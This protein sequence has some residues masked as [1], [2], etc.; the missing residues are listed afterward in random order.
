MVHGTMAKC[1]LTPDEAMAGQW[2]ESWY[3]SDFDSEQHHHDRWCGIRLNVIAK[4]VFDPGD[5][6]VVIPLH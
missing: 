5:K 6:Q 2:N 1:R 3:G 4:T